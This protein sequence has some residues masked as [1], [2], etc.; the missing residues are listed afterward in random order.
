MSDNNNEIKVLVIGDLHFKSSDIE[1]TIIMCKDVLEKTIK[2]EPDII[3]LLGDIYHDFEQIKQSANRRIVDFL[4]SLK[5]IAPIWIIVGNH[6]RPN[7]TEFCTRNHSLAAFEQWE[8]VTIV[9]TTKRAKIH[10]FRFTFVPYVYPGRFEE[11]LNLVKNWEKSD[12]IFAHQAIKGCKMAYNYDDDYIDE[13]DD[14]L[15]NLFCGHDHEYQKVAH[16][17]HYPGNVMQLN[18]GDSTD[19]SISLITFEKGKKWSEERLY[20]DIPCKIKLVVDVEEFLN[21]KT[22]EYDVVKIVIKDT[23]ANIKSLNGNNK[24]K[25][26]RG[27]G[28]DISTNYISNEVMKITNDNDDDAI[29]TDLELIERKVEDYDK[30]LY[31]EISGREKMIRSEFKYLFKDIVKKYKNR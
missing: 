18:Y 30:M 25:K 24:I 2:A 8:N 5:D 26:Y 19:K 29:D 15:P 22:P 1:R 7:N 10:G 4:A 21:M 3:V 20:T 14:S 23:E 9:D 11:A 31:E 12:A 13:W 27:K 17:I 6:D 28:F 16:N